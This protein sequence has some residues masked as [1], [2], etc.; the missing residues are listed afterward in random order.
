FPNLLVLECD[1]TDFVASMETMRTAVEYI[2]RERKPALVRATVTRPYS[3]SLSDDERLYKTQSERDTEAGRDP[4]V[5]YPEW[6]VSE[7]LL[8]RH[9]LQ[10]IVHDVDKEVSKATDRVLK[11]PPPPKG[12]AYVHLYSDKV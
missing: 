2:R 8:D 7:G 1:G 12:S 5:K 11:A 6:L 3:H 9:A 4:I 10:L